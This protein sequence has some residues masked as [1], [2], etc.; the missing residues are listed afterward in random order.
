[1]A[2]FW[3]AASD[4]DDIVVFADAARRE[5][6][7]VLPTLRQQMARNDDRPN[8]ALADFVAPRASGAPD[9]IG[10]FAVTAGAGLEPLVREAEARHDDYE[11]ILLKALAD[12]LAEALAERLHERVRRELWGYAPD[13]RLDNAALIREA[14]QGIR[15][16]P[17]YPACPDH[18]PKRLLFDLLGAEAAIGVQLTESLA[19]LPGA[20][21]SGWYFWR[22]EARYFGVGRIGR[23]QV[24]DLARRTGASLP[25]T[26]RWLGP[27]LGYAR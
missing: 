5:V 6:R 18:R 8:L 11:A 15:P 4:G 23:D 13:E 9:W 16:A 3:P 7:G 17:G 26:E 25:E 14:Y 19:M 21:V 24:E 10:G 27:V 1:V 22:P 12:R 20:S 2:A